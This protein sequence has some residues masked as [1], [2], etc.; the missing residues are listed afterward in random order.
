MNNTLKKIIENTI[1]NSNLQRESDGSIDLTYFWHERLKMLT[2]QQRW[3]IIKEKSYEKRFKNFTKIM[4]EN[5]KHKQ[6]EV[7]KDTFY[8]FI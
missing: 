4:R 2:N 3:D 7:F 5:F 1:N 6:D 8:F